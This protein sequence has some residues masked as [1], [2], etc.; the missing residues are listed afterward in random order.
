MTRFISEQ[1]DVLH[2]ANDILALANSKKGIELTSMQIV[3]LSY[4]AYG[5]FMGMT[6]DRLF[7]NRIEAWKYGPVIPDLYHLTKC[8]GRDPIPFSRIKEQPLKY[9]YL[10]E[11]FVA[12]LGKY[13]EYNGIQLS[14]LTHR[15][16]TPWSQVYKEDVRG[17]EIPDKLIK[18]YYENAL[19]GK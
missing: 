4:I 6:G 15:K 9:D 18:E 11:Y 10:K 19:K 2:V 17:I 12:L 16:G 1:R 14:H 8:F 3:K 7:S 13:G 5:W